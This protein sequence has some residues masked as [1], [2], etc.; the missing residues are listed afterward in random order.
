MPS[1]PYICKSPNSEAL[2][3]AKAVIRH[4]NGNRNVDA[5]HAGFHFELK[6]RAAPPSR[7]K[8]A[9]PFPN[10]LV[11][12]QIYCILVSGRSH[13]AQY[14]PKNLIFVTAHARSYVVEQRGAEKESRL[15]VQKSWRP[16]METVA[17]SSEAAAT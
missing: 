11:V 14:R 1:G 3:S 12:D 15:I 4:R 7:V 8:I 9:V 17:P 13:D 16:S 6:R 10:A 2:P 5:D